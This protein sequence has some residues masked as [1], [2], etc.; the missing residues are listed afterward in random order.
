MTVTPCLLR[1]WQIIPKTANVFHRFREVIFDAVDAQPVAG[2]EFGKRQAVDAMKEKN[3]P[4]SWSEPHKA[5][6]DP[7][8]QVGGLKLR[9]GIGSA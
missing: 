5:R 8:Q 6:L 2:R 4:R 3:G 1:S 9:K 7:A